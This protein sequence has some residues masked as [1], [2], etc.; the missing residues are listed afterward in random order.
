MGWEAFEDGGGD[1]G[2]ALLVLGAFGQGSPP[3]TH[4]T[5]SSWLCQ[6]LRNWQPKLQVPDTGRKSAQPT[7]WEGRGCE[8]LCLLPAGAL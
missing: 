5:Q 1:P 8:R 3:C 7:V 4:L 6:L 2:A